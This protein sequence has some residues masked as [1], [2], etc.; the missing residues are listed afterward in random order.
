MRIGTFELAAGAPPYFI[1]EIG[2]NH[3]NDL[4]RARRMIHQIAAAGGHAAKF[5]TYSAGK[6]ASRYSP[7]YWDRTKEPTDSQFKLFQK[8]DRFGPGEYRALAEECARTGVAFLSTPFD[9]DAVELLSPLVPA[10]KVASADITNLP[11]LEAVA[12]HKKPVLLSTG[13]ST[14][15][16][17]RAAVAFLG[18]HGAPDVALLHCVLSYPTSPENANLAAIAT[19]RRALPE[20]VVG[21]S[22][23]V[24]PDAEML[25][26]TL[27]YALGA[28]VIE[29]HFTDDK[30]LPGNDH[31]HAMDEDD[32]RTAVAQCA[33]ARTLLGTGVKTVG[34]EEAAARRFARRSLVAARAL[35]RGHVLAAE[36][37]EVKRPGTGIPPTEL[38]AV[39]GRRLERDVVVDEVLT[40]DHLERRGPD[41]QDG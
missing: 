19:L 28:R 2:V 26:V 15:D 32:L 23:H 16:E 21:Y 29:K 12:G 5:Q 8:Y 11:L 40:Y 34:P 41:Q 24:P 27:A 33:R 14:L 36:D 20:H 10:F 37:L 35:A 38:E 22:D 18:R 1:A 30:T 17:V 39:L 3:E 25:T 31:Y 7:A 6:L 9:L 4:G 13:A